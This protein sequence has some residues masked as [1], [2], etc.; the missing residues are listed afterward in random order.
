MTYKEA[1][2]ILKRNKPTSDPRLCGKELCTACDVAI[3]AL[4]KQIKKKPIKGTGAECGGYHKTYKY[5]CCPTCGKLVEADDDE[6]WNTITYPT[7]ECGQRIK[8]EWERDENDL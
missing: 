4:E 3:E 6:L 8:Y 5:R 2:E 1:I 7:C